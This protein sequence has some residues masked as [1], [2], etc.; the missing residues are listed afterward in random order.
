MDFTEDIETQVRPNKV[1]NE[2]SESMKHARKHGMLVDVGPS[3]STGRILQLGTAIGATPSEHE[4]VAL[5]LFAFWNRSY[6]R[7]TSGI[8]HFHFVMDMLEN[9]VPGVYK[10]QG[11]PASIAQFMSAELKALEPREHDLAKT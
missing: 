8:H 6:W 11:Y 9:Y 10:F 7:A 5:A 3:F 4:A 2:K 1:L